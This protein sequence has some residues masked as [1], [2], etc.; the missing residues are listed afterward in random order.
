MEEETLSQ[1]DIEDLGK[2]P[3]KRFLYQF[4][5]IQKMRSKK[6]APV[7]TMGCFMLHDREADPKV[8]RFQIFVSLLL[9]PRTKDE[10]TALAVQVRLL[11]LR[12]KYN[13]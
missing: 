3:R 1:E 4:P 9:S 12:F 10:K 6:D 11:T 8:Q 13:V 5:L 7:D 2:N